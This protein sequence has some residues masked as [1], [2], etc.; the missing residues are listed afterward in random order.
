MADSPKLTY[1]EKLLDPRWQKLRVQIL[2]RDAW[3]CQRCGRKDKTLHV[4]HARYDRGDPWETRPELLFVVCADC[5]LVEQDAYR[6]CLNNFLTSLGSLGIQSS[7]DLAFLGYLADLD[8]RE[9]YGAYIEE[10]TAESRA[11]SIAL[12]V[13]IFG[14]EKKKRIAA[15]LWHISAAAQAEE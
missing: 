11:A 5:H 6:D 2:E 1:S 13:V 3:T 8:H 7:I 10:G 14:E 12:A 4:H 15:G 9:R